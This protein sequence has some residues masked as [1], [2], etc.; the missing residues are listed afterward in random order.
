MSEADH[1]TRVAKLIRLLDSSNEPE[2]QSAF[3]KLRAYCADNR[4]QLTSLPIGPTRPHIELTLARTDDS[5]H[6]TIKI[7]EDQQTET[8][9]YC[10]FLERQVEELTKRLAEA[11]ARPPRRK[12]KKATA[13]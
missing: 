9:K 6:R 1:S 10:A 5:T 11:Q 12:R 13:S 3:H 7:F 8:Q 2:A 4:Y